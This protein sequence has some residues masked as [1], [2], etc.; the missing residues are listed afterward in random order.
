MPSAS[1]LIIGIVGL[2]C[3]L[4]VFLYAAPMMA[5]D[6]KIRTRLHQEGA[7]VEGTVLDRKRV[8]IPR[9]AMLFRLTYRYTY[10]GATYEFTQNVR[11][12]LYQADYPGMKL[13]VR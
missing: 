9:A 4:A 6:S 2:V 3:L 8:Y 7:V 13:A 5:N 10:Q 11:R 12:S 1:S